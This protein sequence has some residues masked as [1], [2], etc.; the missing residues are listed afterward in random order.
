MISG[1]RLLPRLAALVTMWFVLDT[2]GAQLMTDH[3]WALWSII[4]LAVVLEMIAYQHG[5]VRGIMIYRDMT[6][7]QRRDIEKIIKENGDA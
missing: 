4:A 6:P 1:G 3:S 2:L 7:E 5:V